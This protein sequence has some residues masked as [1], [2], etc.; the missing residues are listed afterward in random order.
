MWTINLLTGDISEKCL[1]STFLRVALSVGGI[2][3]VKNL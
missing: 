3:L 2:Q 1:L